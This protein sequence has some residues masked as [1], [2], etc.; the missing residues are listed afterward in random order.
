MAF[1]REELGLGNG[2]L[3]GRRNR[4]RL[5][6]ALVTLEGLGGS[7]VGTGHDRKNRRRVFGQP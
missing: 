2:I 1:N 5:R 7:R 4:V 6:G 3:G